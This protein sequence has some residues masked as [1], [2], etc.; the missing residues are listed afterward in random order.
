MMEVQKLH[1]RAT[2]GEILSTEEQ[3]MLESWYKQQDEAEAKQLLSAS[4]LSNSPALQLNNKRAEE[5]Y[6]ENVIGK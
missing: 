4:F 6:R 2:R 1:I 3:A 5:I